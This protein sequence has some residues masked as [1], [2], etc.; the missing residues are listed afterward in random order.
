MAEYPWGTCAAGCGAQPRTYAQISEDFQ[1][2][3]ARELLNARLGTI[4]GWKMGQTEQEAERVAE[5]T[6][7][8]LLAARSTRFQLELN[9]YCLTCALRGQIKAIETGVL[10]RRVAHG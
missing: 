5:Q 3:P 7:R 10:N 9:G 8:S 4:R 2:A 6:A 1:G